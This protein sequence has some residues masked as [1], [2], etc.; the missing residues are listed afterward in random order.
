[1]NDHKK[2]NGIVSW[3]T[4]FWFTLFVVISFILFTSL[5]LITIYPF[6]HS[7]P[8]LKWRTPLLEAK[9][10][11]PATI[12]IREIV[13]LPDQ[14]LIFLNYPLSFHF[15]TKGD[16]QCVYFSTNSEPW[17][18][19]QP[20]QVHSARLHEQ[21]IRCPIPPRGENVSLMIKSNAPLQ[22]KNS[23]IHNSDPLVY[24]S[25]F[26]RDNT[27]IVF[28]KGLNLRPER[29]AEPSKFQCVYGWDFV[30]PKFLLKSDVVSVAQE[31]IRCKTPISI[32]SNE[33]QAYVKVS[34]IQIE[35]NNK[36]IIFPSI[37]RPGLLRSPQNQQNRKAHELCMCTML[38][39]QARFIKEWVMYH[40]KIG[41][42]RWFIYDNNSDDDI[43]KVITF[44][45]SAG[46]NVTWHLW[47]WVK[48]QEAGFAH[49]ALHARG[50]CEWVAFID[51]DEFFNVKVKG[52]LQHVI[53]HYARPENNVAEIRTPCYSFGPSGLKDVPKE[54][55]TVGYTC[56][57]AGK[58]RHKS[59]VR[60][61]ALN[62]TLI[63]V[64]HHFH[65]KAPFVTVDVEK[66]VMVINH[67]KY[68]VWKVFKEK[69]YRRVATYVADWQKEQNVGSK[70]RAP[71]LGTKPI[72][73]PDWS[74]RFCEVKDMGL[75]NWVVRNFM[76]RR[77][78]LFPWQ[79][80]FER[81]FKRKRRRKE[82]GIL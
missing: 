69:F 5:T 45:Q 20:I 3:N 79:P 68:Q 4:F 7:N 53:W 48:T 65:L 81:H 54:G 82:K 9:R 39:N 21:I 43:E 64:V 27:T 80:E 11:A 24:E 15:H 23:S 42:Q 2:R 74:N 17:L 36:G 71:G 58:E 30:K 10:N 40:T 72:E 13:L 8:S 14:V 66:D 6:Y 52:G 26:D 29:L 62:H 1:M 49:C 76:D 46:Y 33:A 51:V 75:R 28:V 18:T 32:S 19:K 34:I 44:L 77:T 59:I 41:V 61:E 78:H 73:P 50:T 35:G 63:N 16:I 22:I 57:L 25:L 47:P 12:T 56:R 37:A 70:D 38:R 55:V 67:Y 31:I 60:P